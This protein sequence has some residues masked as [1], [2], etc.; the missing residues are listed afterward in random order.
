MNGSIYAMRKQVLNLALVALMTLIP[1]SGGWAQAATLNA[2][3][4]ENAPPVF[5][6]FDGAYGQKTNT[7][8]T[9]I[10]FG[11]RQA[12]EDIN[13]AGGVLGGRPVR[14]LTTD[15]KGITA[16]GKD[17]FV[18][19]AQ[20]KD[21]VTVFGGKYSPVTV[22]SLVDAHRL[23]L[24]IISVWGSADQITDHLETPSYSFRVSLKD[25]WGVAAMLNRIVTNLNASTACA[26]LPNTA[27]L[28]FWERKFSIKVPFCTAI[29]IPG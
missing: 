19:L 18:D 7:A 5:L 6:G 8:A 12:I 4:N 1:L 26:L 13:A 24:P 22:E 20:Q 9:A 10:E 11:L 17:N 27:C 14:L 3:A 23:R 2:P 29:T 28:S 21:L 25:S 16:R 15:N